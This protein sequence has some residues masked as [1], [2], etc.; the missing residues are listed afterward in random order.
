MKPT[1]LI[2]KNANLLDTR[3]G[4]IVG[5][6]NIRIE[7]GII[8]E[9]SAG[10]TKPADETLDV[11]GKVVMPGLCDAHVHVVAATASFPDLIT[12]SPSYVA[13]RSGRF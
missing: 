10:S 13:A 3:A 7:D 4:N 11:D 12:W 6:R 8:S 9:I 1:S 2:L 5:K